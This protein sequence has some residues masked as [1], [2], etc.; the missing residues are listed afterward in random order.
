[1]NNEKVAAELLKL[2]TLLM[3][4]NERRALNK[5]AMLLSSE[6]RADAPGVGKKYPELDKISKKI[7][8]EVAKMI[9]KEAANVESEMPYKA[10]YIL[11]TLIPILDKMV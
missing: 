1:M 2:A 8:N 3:P 7:A 11:E 10:Q 9:N 5:A 4:S 6:K